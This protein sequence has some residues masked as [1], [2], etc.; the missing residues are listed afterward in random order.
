MKNKIF[1]CLFLTCFI[2]KDIEAQPLLYRTAIG[3]NAGYNYGITLKHYVST[4]NMIEGI[5][6]FNYG[7]GITLLY[8]FNN[9]H[10]FNVD[11][12]DWYYGVG[13]HAKFVNG[14]RA[15]VFYP[16]RSKHVTL[17]ID[18]ILGLEY[19]FKENPFNIGINIK[20]EL[21][22]TTSNIFW[23]DGALTLRYVLK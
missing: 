14:R 8:E 5:V 6:N 11:E 18:G 23:F 13:A 2:N 10:P 21:N 17:G 20:P 19:T 4:K 3:L 7:P 1:V 9:R 15:N 12:L 16:D 22:F